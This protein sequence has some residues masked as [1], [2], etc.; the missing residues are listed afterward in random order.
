[1]SPLRPTLL[2]LLGALVAPA[3][4]P[5]SLLVTHQGSAVIE[6]VADDG[7]IGPGDGIT[8]T[9]TLLAGEP[10]TGLF[11]RLSS[12]TPG[13]SITR[14]GSGFGDAA[15]GD[16]TANSLAYLATIGADVECGQDLAFSL[17]LGADSG[18]QDIPFVVPTGAAGPLV[19]RDSADVP[20]TI[21]ADTTVSST[22]EI[23]EAGRVKDVRVDLRRIVHGDDGNLKIWLEAP[24]HTAVTLVD[25]RGGSGNDFIDTVFSTSGPS[26]TSSAPPFTGTFAA[27]G[28]LNVLKGRPMQGTWTLHVADFGDGGPGTLVTRGKGISRGQS[29]RGAADGTIHAWD[30][31]LAAATCGGNPIPSFSATPNP[32][33]P[34][35][36][37]TFDASD[38]V[39][40]NGTIVRFEWD[41]DGD[42]SFETDTG[43]TPSAARAY[44]SKATVPVGLRVTDDSGHQGSV[45][46]PLAVTHAPV[47]DFSYTPSHPVTGD[48]ITLDAGASSD[49]D[50]AI[51]GYT[52]DL[53]GNGSFERDGGAAATT[54]FVFSRPGIHTVRLRVADDTGAVSTEAV[55]VTVANRA[56]AAL[57]SGPQTATAGSPATFS[58]TGSTD[59][60][61]SIVR[62]EWQIDGAG[63][64]TDTGT[65][66]AWTVA[67]D[68]PGAHV[69]AVRV[70]D[71][72]GGSATGT[73]T[74][75]VAAPEAAGAGPRTSAGAGP[76]SDPGP[77]PATPTRKDFSAGLTGAAI[78]AT[79]LA[80][81]RGITLSCRAVSLARCSLTARLSARDARKLGLGRRAGAARVVGRA[82]VVAGPGRSGRVV[83][84]LSTALRRALRQARQVRLIVR[85]TAVD[86]DGR[87]VALAR[88]IILRG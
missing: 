37:A 40:P 51:T 10:L 56:P 70:T 60:D 55:D 58:A 82:V 31:R 68:T 1:M 53:D 25:R 14:T 19:R 27:D 63:S 6:Q 12:P 23:A 43:T 87:R 46:L 36:T 65:S 34:G 18:Q 2:V 78:Q 67:W 84:P 33:L 48:T 73:L 41:L 71:D 76:G 52:W 17:D 50:G 42:G 9:E 44:P 11:G 29:A 62:Y 54:T 74:V 28:D 5:A 59:S 72:L 24:D 8:L 32:V 13:V 4:A 88:A 20:R 30:L 61:G 64:W 35:A 7:L 26:V 49:A 83:M 77:P 85:G 75:V 86:P 66:P 47:A 39:D 3:A 81:S 45:S 80:R 38:S 79:R 57:L 16:T 15:A 69:V 22:L 21:L